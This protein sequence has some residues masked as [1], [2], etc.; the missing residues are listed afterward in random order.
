MDRLHKIYQLHG[1]LRG[2]RTVAPL[3]LIMEHLECSRATAGRVIR[4]MR[5]YL[6]APLDYDREYKGYRYGD[7]RFELP[8][9]WFSGEEILALLTMQKLL[10]QVGP[11]LLDTQLAPFRQR[12]EKMLESE[13]LGGGEVHRI[14]ILPIAARI[15]DD[16][17]FQAVAGALLQR[18]QMEIGYHARGSDAEAL[19]IVSPQRLARYRDN[20]YLDAW[21]HNREALR[22]FA[23]DRIRHV[24]VLDTPADN[25]PDTQ[26]DAHFADG[27]GIFAGKAEHTAILRFTPERARWVADEYWH[28]QQQRRFFDNGAYELHIPYADP[29]EL[30]MD[31][32]RYV[33]EVEVV[34]P[35]ELRQEVCTRLEAA[36][37][38]HTS[39]PS[40]EN[41]T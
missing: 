19:R 34:A 6:Q 14:R 38:L 27:Y 17:M 15:S 4:E 7:E 33:P 11:G 10:A 26:L 9:L 25:I 13:H 30:I 18:R 39:T 41:S 28:P 3:S 21:C 23:V 5:D 20:W 22:S 31:I 37:Q 36:L 2:R 24:N 32:L 12:I 40:N 8:G 35:E 29:R 16:A 1:L